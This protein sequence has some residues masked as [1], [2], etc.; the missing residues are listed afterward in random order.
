MAA[1]A[2]VAVWTIGSAVGV[3]FEAYVE[4]NGTIERV[5]ALSVAGASLLAGLAGG[6]AAGI[7]ARL[8]RK[9]VPVVAVAGLFLTAVSLTGPL[10][11]PPEV[12]AS[13][14]VLLS[15]MNLIAGLTVTAGLV[16]GLTQD[17]RHL[18]G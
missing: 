6:L 14:R 2:N 12:P 9:P 8:L 7:V 16:R 18:A 1:A 17:D 4:V 5:T 10:A 3:P 15:L 11:Q 13:T